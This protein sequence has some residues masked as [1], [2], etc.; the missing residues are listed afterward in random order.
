MPPLTD[1]LPD[2]PAP[3]EAAA[4]LGAAPARPRWSERYRGGTPEAERLQFLALANLM[5]DAQVRTRRAAGAKRVDRA[6]HARAIAAFAGGRLVFADN[7]PPDLVVGFAR[8]G[9][10]Y[11]ACVRFS[12]AASI[13]GSDEEKDLRGLAVRIEA[14]AGEHHDLL[15]TNYPV[16]HARDAEQFVRFAHAVAGGRLSRV[17]GLLGL[18]GRLGPRETLRML[19]NIRKAR[20]TCESVALET[21]WSR[22]AIRWGDE[23][24]RYF[25][26]PVTG[27][28]PVAGSFSGV[29]R[30]EA[31]YAARQ[32]AGEVAFDLLVQ[33]FV[34]EARTPIEDAAHA[35]DETVSPP[36]R[37]ATLTL[38][39]R[40]LATADAAAERATIEA[41]GFNPWNTTEEFRPLGNLNRARKA[42]YDASL[43]HRGG[44]RWRADPAPLQNRVVGG[45][46]RGGF[47]ALNRRVPWH[48][49]PTL[50]ALLN[51]DT[52]RHDLR[53]TNLVDTETREA[54]PTARAL[55]PATTGTARAT[56]S[57]TGE[58]NDLSDPRMGAVGA[59][60]GRNMPLEDR[61]PD[62]PN[63]VTVARELMDR[64]AFIPARSLNILAAAWIQFQV[65]DWVNHARRRLGEDDLAVRIP[66]RYPAWANTPGGVPGR[67]MRI[68]GNRP[69]SPG[70]PPWVFTNQAS[71]WWDGSE[72]YGD[73]QTHAEMLREGARL[74]LDGGYLPTDL[75][76]F[77][78]TGFNE[79]WWLGLSAMHTLFAREH[80]LIVEE[81]AHTYPSWD[82]ERRYHT[83]RLVISAIIAKIHTIE[84]TP[85]IL[86]TRSLEIG[87][88][89]N[90]YGP[91]DRLTRLGVWLTDAHAL[92][93]IPKTFPDHHAAPYSL[94]EEFTAVYRMHPLIPDDYI[95]RDFASGRVKGRADFLQIQG[96][97]A[98][99]KMRELGLR[100]ALYS[101]GIAHPGAITLHNFPRALQHFE[102]DGE[103]VDLSVVDI[104]R[105]R[106]RRVPRY[107][108]FRTAL[109]M[110]RLRDWSEFTPD[111]ETN[112]QLR[113]IYRDVDAVDTVIG[114]LGENPP[115]GFGFS[116]TA[117]RI[118][119]LMASRRLQSD[120]FLTV[121]FR[122]EIYS[123]LG[124]DWVE[125]TTMTSLI[126][127]HFPEFAH[128]LPRDASAF[129][130]WHAVPEAAP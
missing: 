40:E 41:T 97:D 107:N 54:T 79:S 69:A 66:D 113:E 57:F 114:L 128:V 12:N 124:M 10:G 93:G 110:P 77:E 92:R 84:W 130:P 22:G 62:E 67:E 117:F 119:I 33:R 26:R 106:A 105:T 47:R 13:P 25:F 109:R 94:T 31:E 83:A 125:N 90:W 108:G 2:A 68:A 44:L 81:L 103:V 127:R 86:G 112:R 58:G 20:R 63:A 80:N 78:V 38:P 71:H 34:D 46:V 4:P 55:P 16:P 104:L 53:T 64:H 51:I 27:T 111:P 118:F 11:P 120:R 85:A 99:D 60:F 121:D 65:H 96:A 56:R 30:L 72:V 102:R 115:A 39:A 29:G 126:L 37:V 98:D 52:L 18:L 8:P 49:L 1:V 91:A 95:F 76:G 14:G 23:A 19:G 32:R 70:G 28:P 73:D 45:A 36:V 43:A 48:R 9:A 75:K 42:V 123:P 116:D 88:K 87:M 3:S 21:Y 100:D 74:R 35:W 17:T 24:V 7:L 59:T 61:P 129:A 82:D 122:P 6:F 89:A 15:A 50:V 101:F 5:L